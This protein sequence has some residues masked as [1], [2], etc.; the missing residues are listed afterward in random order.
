MSK[1]DMGASASRGNALDTANDVGRIE[2][3]QGPDPTYRT[4]D[5]AFPAYIGLHW[6]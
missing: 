6:I 5:I 2:K 1:A 3:M 4:V